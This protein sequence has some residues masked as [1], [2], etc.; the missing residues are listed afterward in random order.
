MG[1]AHGHLAAYRWMKHQGH[2]HIVNTAS[3]AGLTPVPLLAAYAMSKHAVVGLS[4]RLRAEGVAHGVKVSA[5]CPAAINTPLLESGGPA[6][7]PSLAWRPDL[8][9]YLTALA[10]APCSAQACVD[11]ALRG[12][13]RNRG[14]IVLPARAR[15]SPG[16][17]A[18]ARAGGAHRVGA[19]AARAGGALSPVT[20]PSLNGK[21]A[22][23]LAAR[24]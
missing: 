6:D 11:D 23:S 9:A 5:I 4:L 21:P 16:L 10:G 24:P 22:A 13:E 2:G 17:S 7:L 12:V 15:R 3:L 18:A 1:V 8:R 14:L 20:W 19:A